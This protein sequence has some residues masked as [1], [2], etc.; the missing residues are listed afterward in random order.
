MKRIQIYAAAIT[1]ALVPAVF[2]LWGNASFSRAVPVRV[3]DSAQTHHPDDDGGSRG[4][5]DTPFASPA[6]PAASPTARG[7]AED[8]GGHSGPGGGEDPRGHDAGDD[9]GGSGRGGAHGSGKDHRGSGHDDR[10]SGGGSGNDGD[11]GSGGHG[12]ND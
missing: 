8:R 6:P 9:H 7:T 2:G 5:H 12:S 10:D 3:P 1:L 4:G 11:G